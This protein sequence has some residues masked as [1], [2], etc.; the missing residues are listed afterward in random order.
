[1]SFL[2]LQLGILRKLAKRK[3]DISLY[4]D[5]LGRGF[6]AELDYR[7]E[8]HNASEFLVLLVLLVRFYLTSKF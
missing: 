6:L 2:V 5:E 8:A 3:S 7:I 4:A 1:M